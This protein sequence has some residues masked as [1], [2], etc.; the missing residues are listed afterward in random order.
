MQNLLETGRYDKPADSGR[1]SSGPQNILKRTLVDASEAS[2]ALLKRL[3]LG[4]FGSIASVASEARAGQ[5]LQKQEDT[6]REVLSL[7]SEQAEDRVSEVGGTPQSQRAPSGEAEDASTPTKSP[8]ANKDLEKLAESPSY[9]V[10]RAVCREPT[11]TA[12]WRL[13][14]IL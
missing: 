2:A 1:S 3:P 12:D 4:G 14:L 6:N 7:F 13:F 10:R 11:A 8:K 5:A 9:K